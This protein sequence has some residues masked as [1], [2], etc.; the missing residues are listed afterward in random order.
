MRPRC[1]VALAPERLLYKDG[2]HSGKHMPALQR[3][4]I[5]TAVVAR[6]EGI[7]VAQG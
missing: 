7:A 3:Q 6:L 1:L 5:D 4:A 2:H